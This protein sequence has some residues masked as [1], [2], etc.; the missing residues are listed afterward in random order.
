M[1]SR[2]AKNALIED[3]SDRLTK[4]QEGV[5]KL[6]RVGLVKIIEKPKEEEKVDGTESRLAIEAGEE[7]DRPVAETDKPKLIEPAPTAPSLEH[8][9]LPS[10]SSS[11]NSDSSS[12]TASPIP[13]LSP[14]P[15]PPAE[16]LPSSPLSHLS[17]LLPLLSSSQYPAQP[18]PIS[19]TQTLRS[20]VSHLNSQSLLFSSRTSRTSGGVGL[21]SLSRSLEGAGGGSSSEGGAAWGGG[22]GEGEKE[23][24]GLVSG[25]RGDVRGLKGLLISRRVKVLI[26]AVPNSS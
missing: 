7:L 10:S 24:I 15:D 4:L 19:L 14:F 23:I 9:E 13:T 5:D 6:M 22:L 1:L 26:T 21:A 3:H 18:S 11:S 12:S 20:V 25:M 8:D 17:P 16:Y 2:Q